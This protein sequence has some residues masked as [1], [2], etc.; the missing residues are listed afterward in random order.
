MF[1]HT[2]ALDFELAEDERPDVVISV[3]SERFLMVLPND[4]IGPTTRQI[5]GWKLEAGDVRPRLLAWPEAE[6]ET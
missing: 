2:S 1:A 5:A 6:P 4:A 3:M